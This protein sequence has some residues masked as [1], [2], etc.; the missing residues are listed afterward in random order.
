VERLR[1]GGTTIFVIEH[2][3]PF[4]MAISDEVWVM[5]FGEVVAH[6]PPAAIRADQLV[7][8]IYLGA[9]E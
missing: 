7:R 1:E 6:G 4:V 3:V 5:N 9:S 2:N 8:D